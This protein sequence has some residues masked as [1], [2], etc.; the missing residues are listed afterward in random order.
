MFVG[1]SIKGVLQDLQDAAVLE[2]DA[3][4]ITC[5]RELLNIIMYK[6]RG[7]RN[8]SAISHPAGIMT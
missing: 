3:I 8:D 4:E 6:T 1:N 7:H 2:C 5:T